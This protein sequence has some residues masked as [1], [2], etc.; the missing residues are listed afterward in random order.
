MSERSQIAVVW[1]GIGLAILYGVS[2][3]F[4]LHMVP[5]PSA[6]L[7]ADAVAAFYR[8]HGTS[9]RVGAMIDSWCGAFMLPLSAVIAVQVA[10][11]EQG[12]IW[13][14]LTE[15]GGMAVSIF[16]V[17]P[18]IFWGVAAFTPD[19][20]P[21]ITQIM[22]QLAVLTLVTTDQF[23]IFMWVAVMFVCFRATTVRHSPFPRWFGW[24]TAWTFIMFEAG[25]VAFVTR[26]GPFAWDG[27]LV[28]WSP[29]I[30]FSAWLII[31]LRLVLKAL[32]RQLLEAQELEAKSG[33]P[34]AVDV[35]VAPPATV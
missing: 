30:L 28:F 3:V 2:L 33:A 12:R 23:Y 34:Q 21:E 5:P 13:A 9:I 26:M 27:L 18:P 7:S 15:L 10:R 4:M 32:K 29:V 1:W 16:L 14:R 20:A 24:F 11:V 22:H 25:A 31:M 19:R 8:E 17:L 6:M 35:P